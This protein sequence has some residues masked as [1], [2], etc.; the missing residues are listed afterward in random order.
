MKKFLL[1]IT[2]LFTLLITSC[3]SKPATLP[4]PKCHDETC[5]QQAFAEVIEQGGKKILFI[6]FQT[7]DL[8]GNAYIGESI[9]TGGLYLYGLDDKVIQ[10][11]IWIGPINCYL[12]N[13]FPGIEIEAEIMSL[14]GVQVDFSDLGNKRL[15]G[16]ISRPY[17]IGD[18]IWVEAVAFEFQQNIK[19]ES[20]SSTSGSNNKG[21]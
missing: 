10:H 11:L 6:L 4:E 17:E 15:F 2:L 19:I 13:D 1:F 9:S 20:L 14:C 16:F 12:Y 21:E 8:E 18:Y 7:T 3:T 5:I